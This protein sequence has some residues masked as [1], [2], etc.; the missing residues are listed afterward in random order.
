L[1]VNLL[2]LIVNTMHA[3]TAN[4]PI[5]GEYYLQGVME[6]ASGF[7]L[8]PDHSFEFFFSYGALDRSGHGQWRQEKNAI[9]FNSAKNKTADYTLL[10]TKK[11]N[12]A[13]ITVSINGGNEYLRKKIHAVIMH[14]GKE[15][16]AGS[17]EKG[18]ILAKT[19]MADSIILLFEWCPEKRFVFAVPDTTHNYF[20]F[21]VEPALLDVV[22]EDFRLQLN[23]DGFTGPH[24]LDLTKSFDYKRSER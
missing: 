9:V 14:G 13:G 16:Q 24:P 6:T 21:R 19:A 12:I 15:E 11:Q 3:Q 2:F 4:P 22:F 23:A 18:I 20:E 7:K 5:T 8:N 1:L 17:N 10:H